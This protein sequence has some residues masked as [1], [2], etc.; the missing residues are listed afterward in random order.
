MTAVPWKRSPCQ[1]QH[2][3]RLRVVQSQSITGPVAKIGRQ[4][5]QI[6]ARLPFFFSHPRLSCYINWLFLSA[7][8]DAAGLLD[9]YVVV[10]GSSCQHRFLKHFKTVLTP[11]HFS[12]EDIGR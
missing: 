11:E 12:L 8:T 3:G 7:L 4:R 6:L 5:C 1:S 9:S 10:S 2:V